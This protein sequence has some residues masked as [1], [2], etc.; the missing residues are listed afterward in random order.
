MYKLAVPIEAIKILAEDGDF[1]DPVDE[2]KRKRGTKRKAE[3]GGEE[4]GSSSGSPKR[5]KA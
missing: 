3:D 5:A 2:L 4:S 1:A